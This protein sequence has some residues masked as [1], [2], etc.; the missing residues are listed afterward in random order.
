MGNAFDPNKVLGQANGVSSDSAQKS[1]W[2]LSGLDTS[3]GKVITYQYEPHLGPNNPRAANIPGEVDNPKNPGDQTQSVAPQVLMRRPIEYYYKDPA[4]Y[5]DFQQRLFAGGFYGATPASSIPWGTDPQGATLDAW[6]KVLIAAQQAQS[7]GYNITPDQILQQGIE[8][9][10]A[11]IKNAPVSKPGMIVQ[12]SDPAALTGIVQQAAQASLHRNLS[13]D[14][15]NRFIQEFHAQ[16]AAYSK[17]NYQAQLDTTG[18]EFDLTQP[19]AQAQAEQFVQQG[20]PA[21]AGGELLASYMAQL[22]SM[23]NG[24]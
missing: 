1:L 7:S 8:Q 11:A 22:Q 10:Q 15:I 21:E 24:G 19:N 18:K 9:H 23:L 6:K 3:P 20:H 14:E 16:E 2:D 4:K 5:L 13:P 17:K 12:Y